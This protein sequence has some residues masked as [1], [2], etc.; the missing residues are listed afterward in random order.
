M[1]LF[2]VSTHGLDIKSAYVRIEEWHSWCAVQRFTQISEEKKWGKKNK[3]LTF[4]EI[5][6][7]K[8]LME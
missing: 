6:Q 5:T 3:D 2:Y 7:F 4:S 8:M 1:S